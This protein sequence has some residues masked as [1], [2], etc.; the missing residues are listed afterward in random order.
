MRP[1]EHPGSNKVDYLANSPLVGQVLFKQNITTRM[2][3]TKA[4][5]N[6]NRLTTI[7]AA[8]TGTTPPVDYGYD[9]LGQVVDA[10]G[11]ESGGGTNRV[12]ERFG[13]RYDAM[14]NLSQR[15]NNAFVKTFRLN[16]L[17]Q[18]TNAI[19]SGTMTVAG[20]TFT[21]ASSVTVAANGGGAVPAILYADAT[22]ARTNVTLVNGTNTSVA[23]GTDS[24]GRG[25]TNTS[26]SRT[27]SSPERCPYQF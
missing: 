2:T 25:D 14:G 17:N 27:A 18:L 13:Y 6:L 16:K 1:K 19:R 8:G 4:H 5:D 26:V 7:T 22:F 9:A 20:T 23:A 11:K 24:T 12:H 3:T 10:T 15:T 21:N